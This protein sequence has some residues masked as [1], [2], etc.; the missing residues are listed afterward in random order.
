MP[1]DE[2]GDAGAIQHLAQGRGQRQVQVERA[3]VVGDRR[4]RPRRAPRRAA[5]AI[6]PTTSANVRGHPAGVQGPLQAG[7][8]R[9]A[10][11]QQRDL[12]EA[13]ARIRRSAPPGDDADLV[14]GVG[15]Q[16]PRAGPAPAPRRRR[17]AGRRSGPG[18]SASRGPAADI[19]RGHRAIPEALRQQR[20]QAPLED[21][22]R[23]VA[24]GAARSSSSAHSAARPG[25]SRR[26]R[27]ASMVAPAD[28][29][30]ELHD[31]EAVGPDVDLVD[32][33]AVHDD[34]PAMVDG[35][36]EGVAEPLD[37]R[38]VRHQV[39]LRVDVGE[40]VDAAPVGRRRPGSAPTISDSKRTWTSEQVA[41]TPGPARCSR[42]PRRRRRAR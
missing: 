37:A 36:E 18:R 13:D 24:P 16:R 6:A 29:V 15:H 4:R 25:S 3:D 28:V 19:A 9:M 34:R 32:R 41:R 40:R 21:R 35:L 2:P 27:A 23:E 17:R 22:E 11:V 5:S 10:R 7:D 31:P 20:G 26:R 33:V 1:Q 12:D 38:R 42:R 8:R 14:S 39:R 30:V